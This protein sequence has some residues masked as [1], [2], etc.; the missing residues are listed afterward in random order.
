[1]VLLDLTLHLAVDPLMAVAW[2]SLGHGEALVAAVLLLVR[3]SGDVRVVVRG[4]EGR[5]V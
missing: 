2:A 5:D 4:K 1:V 3:H